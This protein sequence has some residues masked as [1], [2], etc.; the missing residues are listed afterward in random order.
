MLEL[1]SCVP[2]EGKGE[3]GLATHA[4]EAG[5][6]GPA[7]RGSALTFPTLSGTILP[8]WHPFIRAVTSFQKVSSNAG[9]D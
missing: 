8:V 1:Q 9:R 2:K 7:Q 3:A 4:G 6:Q 5:V